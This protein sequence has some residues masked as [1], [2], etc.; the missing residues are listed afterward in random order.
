MKIP[1]PN[2]KDTFFAMVSFDSVLLYLT[3][4]PQGSEFFKNDINMRK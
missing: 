3:F 2:K 4:Y 1:R